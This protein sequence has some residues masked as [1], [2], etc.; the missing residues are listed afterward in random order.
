MLTLTRLDHGTTTG[1][2]LELLASLPPL[3]TADLF[4]RDE[5]G[6]HALAVDVDASG[7]ITLRFGRFDVNT[8]NPA[9]RSFV[10]SPS[11]PATTFKHTAGAARVAALWLAC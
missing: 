10:P 11:M 7:A 8:F 6:A 5:I 4:E 9:L 1:A 2:A 3:S